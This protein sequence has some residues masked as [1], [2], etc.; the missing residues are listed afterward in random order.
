MMNESNS[1]EAQ[2]LLNKIVYDFLKQ[3]K[4]QRRWQWMKR[5]AVFLV[6]GFVVA[7]IV[8]AVLEEKTLMNRPHVG[9]IDIKGEISDKSLM[10]SD[11]FS[12]SIAKAYKNE[13]M[14]ALVLRINSPGGSP[15]QA[16]YM[17]NT[18]QYYRQKYPKIKTY[19]VCMDSCASAAYYIAAAADEIYANPSSLVG[20]IGVLYDGFG[21][22]EIM[23]KIGITRRLITAGK[24]KG[25]LDPFSPQ[26]PEQKAFLQTM[27]DQIHQQFI[28]KVKQGRGARL[29]MNDELFTGLAW[30]GGQAKDLGLIDGFA[31]T[32]ELMRQTLKLEDAIDYTEKM[33]VVEQVSRNVGAE[34]N[35]LLTERVHAWS[36]R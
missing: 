36:W 22:D 26:S 14:Q 10:N 31:S 8:M 32:G 30:T 24:N 4:H 3:Q 9:I 1:Q 15:V 28:A 33:S 34:L 16:D 21:F 18:I 11:A 6:L 35:G 7:N 5:I 17:Y 2:L 13:K 19:A 25:F 12:K 20:S 23:Q 27:L 29:K